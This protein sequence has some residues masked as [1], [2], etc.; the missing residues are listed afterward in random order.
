[1]IL[2]LFINFILKF[3]CTKKGFLYCTRS[4]VIHIF[5]FVFVIHCFLIIERERKYCVEG[6]EK[7]GTLLD[8]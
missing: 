6:K 7:K 5:K 1:M 8:Y 4:F 2:L 3:K